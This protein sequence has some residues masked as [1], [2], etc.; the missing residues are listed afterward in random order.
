MRYNVAR[1]GVLTHLGTV[2][3]PGSI[4]WDE[5]QE[6]IV[7]WTNRFDN[8]EMIMGRAKDIQRQEDGWITA[9]I[10]WIDE[11]IQALVDGVNRDYHLTIW[12]NQV[13]SKM[14]YGK[15]I[16]STCTVKAFFV[17][18]DDKSPWHE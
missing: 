4:Q 16:V 14:E 2:F 7:T 5:D 3:Q 9:D 6:Y 10:T 18:P 1:E 13:G 8:P 11:N 17:S 12:A 15:K